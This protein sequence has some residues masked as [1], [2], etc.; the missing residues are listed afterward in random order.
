[1][2]NVFLEICLS[3][4]SIIYDPKYYLDLERNVSLVTQL[5]QPKAVFGKSIQIG[6]ISWLTE[7]GVD[8][9]SKASLKQ[10]LIEETNN[11]PLLRNSWTSVPF[12]SLANCSDLS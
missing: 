9:F 12:S 5:K 10:E 8:P 2:T 1:M 3:K 4:D 11:D 6:K 7:N